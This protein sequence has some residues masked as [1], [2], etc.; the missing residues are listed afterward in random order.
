MGIGYYYC[1]RSKQPH[2]RSFIIDSQS[3]LFLPT[4]L[5]SSLPL[6]SP[7]PFTCEIFVTLNLRN[8]INHTICT[9]FQW[10]VSKF[11]IWTCGYNHDLITFS[12]IEFL[13]VCVQSLLHSQMNLLAI[14]MILCIMNG[15]GAQ[16]FLIW[17][18]EH[19]QCGAFF[20][21]FCLL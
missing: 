3:W 16:H 12:G 10:K 18:S 6:G 5:P 2:P 4:L 8:L 17:I 11:E 20:F 13:L 19:F 1:L 14:I 9:K 7:P 21:L 15:W